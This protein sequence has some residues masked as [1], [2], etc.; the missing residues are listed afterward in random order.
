MNNKDKL[1][2]IKQEIQSMTS[3]E[4]VIE[5]LKAV[6]L[7][8]LEISEQKSKI[9]RRFWEQAWRLSNYAINSL[10]DKEVLNC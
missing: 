4:D 2:E 10:E 8:I 9:N 1:Q 5:V 3:D 7:K 6:N